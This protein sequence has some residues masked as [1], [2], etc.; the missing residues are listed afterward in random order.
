MAVWMF[1]EGVTVIPEQAVAAPNFTPPLPL[2]PLTL[3]AVA[4]PP[5][6]PVSGS[7]A[8]GVCAAN[9]A[10]TS[11]APTPAVRTTNGKALR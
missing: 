1:V 5:K 8:T 2:A 7:N 4:P 3:T 9:V 11:K 10:H 6:V